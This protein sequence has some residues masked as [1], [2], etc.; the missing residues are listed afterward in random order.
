MNA[1]SPITL[2]SAL[3][4]MLAD[5]ADAARA[6]IAGRDRMVA[7]ALTPY[8]GDPA[9]LAGRC[10]DAG[11]SCYARHLLHQDD[12]AG[13][14]V[15][16]IVWTPGQMS[17]VHGHRTWCALGIQAG[18]LTETFFRPLDSVARPVACVARWPGDV[19]HS[20]ADPDSI[21]RIANLGTERAISVHVYGVCF[22]KFGTGVNHV[23]AS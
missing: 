9:L 6:P 23:W 21:H 20:P 8:L 11:T 10:C 16:S 17:P 3:S 2:P 5:V 12:A 19:S 13:Y 4:R 7:A 14:A 18:W 22:D 1:L 15:V